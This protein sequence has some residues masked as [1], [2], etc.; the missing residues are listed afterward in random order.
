MLEHYE[1]NIIKDGEITS[2]TIAVE[3]LNFISTI[4]LDFTE[5][6]FEMISGVRIDPI[7]QFWNEKTKDDFDKVFAFTKFLNAVG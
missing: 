7:L 4:M 5:I 2:K 3:F 1:T 6:Y